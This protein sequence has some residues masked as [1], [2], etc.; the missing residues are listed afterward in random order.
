MQACQYSQEQNQAA[1][2]KT[3]YGE[4]FDANLQTA[5]NTESRKRG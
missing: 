5:N 1:E 3:N 4:D 2:P